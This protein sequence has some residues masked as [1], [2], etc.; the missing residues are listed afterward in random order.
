MTQWG[1][2]LNETKTQVLYAGKRKQARE[3]L[4]RNK[5]RI[6]NAKC[7][8]ANEIKHLGAWIT[9]KKCE[10]R[11]LKSALQS[12]WAAY[13]MVRW[14][15]TKNGMSVRVTRNL[16]TQIIMPSFFYVC[17]AWKFTKAQMDKLKLVERKILR[18]LSGMYR[19]PNGKYYSNEE[20]Y[21]KMEIGKDIEERAKERK[22]K[23][24]KALDTMDNQWF[25]NRR[26][27]LKERE[28]AHDEKEI[29]IK[30]W[31]NERAMEREE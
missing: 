3:F 29:F 12:G 15:A 17:Q 9:N 26:R 8:E 7:E 25:K 16:Y 23:Y 18:K 4:T 6:G 27:E 1:I 22:E 10:D 28:R 11:N 24:E 19:R 2:L 13:G 21:R 5:I 14:I 20:L 31:K 30:Q